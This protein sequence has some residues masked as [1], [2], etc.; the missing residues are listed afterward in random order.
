V[1]AV[2][3]SDTRGT[4]EP[5][6][7]HGPPRGC[8]GGDATP[9]QSRLA[10][11]PEGEEGEEEDEGEGAPRAAPAAAAACSGATAAAAAKAAAAAAAQDQAQV[12]PAAAAAH[13]PPSC[14]SKQVLAEAAPGHLAARHRECLSYAAP[15]VEAEFG[16]SINQSLQFIVP[17]KIAKSAT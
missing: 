9:P 7:L 3:G 5:C 16:R 13:P 2:G 12:A 11:V 1:A 6:R 10:S 14:L 8:G 4:R 15:A 17:T